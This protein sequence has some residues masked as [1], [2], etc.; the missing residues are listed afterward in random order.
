LTPKLTDR[1]GG[2]DNDGN[3]DG[4]GNYDDCGNG[5]SNDGNY[6]DR[7][8]GGSNDGNDD[9]SDDSSDGGS[10]DGGSSNGGAYYGQDVNN[11]GYDYDSYVPKEW[12]I[13][14]DVWTITCGDQSVPCIMLDD[15]VYDWF[16]QRFSAR[17]NIADITLNV[18]DDMCGHVFV[19]IKLEFPATTD[20]RDDAGV[21]VF[22]IDAR[23]H[24]KFFEDMVASSML[25]FSR[26][27]QKMLS[28]TD[29]NMVMIQL[30]SRERN[31]Y[32][33]ELIH[34]GLSR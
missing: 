17:H 27:K 18:F 24:V 20:D 33:L 30:P 13:H 8:N 3:G 14:N 12:T 16:V 28:S 10:S 32:A 1:F 7:G 29:G 31:E 15:S 25:A 19:E 21:E 9:S 4:D 2:A 11:D 26:L 6:D 22:M 23:R 34:K 5:G